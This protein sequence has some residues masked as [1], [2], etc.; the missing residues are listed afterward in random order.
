MRHLGGHA[1]IKRLRHAAPPH[2][3]AQSRYNFFLSL[4][5]AFSLTLFMTADQSDTLK[6]RIGLT[7]EL[8]SITMMMGL[9]T[10][11]FTVNPEIYAAMAK[12]PRHRFVT[13]RYSRLTYQNVAL[14]L[15]GQ[16]HM[17]PE[18]FITSIM[19]QMMDVS[20]GDRILDI[21]FGTGYEAAILSQ[22]AGQVY[23]IQQSNPMEQVRHPQ[24]LE[25]KGYRNVLTR[26]ADGA[27]GW[28]EKGPFDAI[29]VRQSM[30]A[31][32]VALLRQLKPGGRLVIPIGR[33]HEIQELRVYTRT[34]DGDIEQRT[35][36]NVALTPLFEGRE[37]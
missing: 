13:P 17:M 11:I 22:I 33:P 28:A 32:P 8:R 7:H 16:A 19:V 12:V 4:F 23:V 29:L 25:E 20:R 37:I 21:G 26:K 34:E 10:G 9:Y 27:F 31:P 2:T 36:L 35:T 24:P 30:V 5:S 1:K 15:D 6:Q 14:P 3:S 18:P